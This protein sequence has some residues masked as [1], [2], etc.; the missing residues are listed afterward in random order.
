MPPTI[1][2]VSRPGPASAPRRC[3][4]WLAGVA[5]AAL[6]AWGGSATA[7]SRVAL[8]IGNATYNTLPSLKNAGN[9]SKAVTDVLSATGFEIYSGANLTRL[10]FDE[11]VRRFFRAANGA[12]VALVYY[13]GH[14]VQ[15][16]G[17][18]FL[19][20]VDA[21]LSTPYDIEQQTIDVGEIHAYLTQHA[22][23]QLIFLDA[24]RDNP[25]KID[26]FWI[27]DSLKTVAQTRGLARVQDSAALSAVGAAPVTRSIGSLLAFSTEPGNVALDGTGELSPYTSAFVRHAPTA[28]LE[29]RQVLTQV[30]RDVIASTNGAQVP[31][32]NSSLIDDVYLFRS[33]PPPVVAPMTKVEANAGAAGPM[34]LPTPRQDGGREMRAQIDRLP[35]RGALLLAGRRLNQG[36]MISLNDL[37]SLDYDPLETPAGTID[38]MGYS[39]IDAWGQKS[40]GVAAISIGAGDPAKARL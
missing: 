1:E 12:D 38:L 9:D 2:K 36:D 31:W 17:R 16:A 25:F 23:A 30:R 18:N 6:I 24:C 32:E 4:L 26:R 13:S 21:T 20:P 29:I 10:Q 11:V 15:V 33:P 8:V 37:L 28:N 14:G 5:S 22:K 35:E 27:A 34:R 39:V 7:A 40:Q 3:L 19:V